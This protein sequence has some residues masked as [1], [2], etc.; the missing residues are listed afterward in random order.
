MPK[1]KCTLIKKRKKER[2]KERKKIGSSL[3]NLINFLKLQH[4]QA[5]AIKVHGTGEWLIL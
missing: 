2:E 1:S 3:V 5:D 4:I